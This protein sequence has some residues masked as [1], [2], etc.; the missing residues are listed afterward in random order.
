[1][2]NVE[3][4]ELEFKFGIFLEKR[5]YEIPKNA[6]KKD[7]ERFINYELQLWIQQIVNDIY[8]KNWS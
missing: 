6:H 1:M 5:I 2:V 4:I 8:V 3:N 7:V